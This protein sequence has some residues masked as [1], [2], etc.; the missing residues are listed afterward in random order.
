M[1]EFYAPL[2][3]PTHTGRGLS[4]FWGSLTAAPTCF[5]GPSLVG[6]ERRTGG[7]NATPC[8]AFGWTIRRC[9]SFRNPV[10][11]HSVHASLA[12]WI[13]RR[14]STP[15]RPGFES[16][17]GHGRER[18]QG[19]ATRHFRGSLSAALTPWQ[20]PASLRCSTRVE[21]LRVRR[22]GGRRRP[23]MV[24]AQW[25]LRASHLHGESTSG[26][27]FDSSQGRDGHARARLR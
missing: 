25:L 8:E 9:V 1:V 20:L 26:V 7:R 18:L 2:P 6:R 3:A 12:Q 10:A 22:Y 11:S 15:R 24:T 5:R 4:C 21:G 14:S 13:E 17:V 23:L 19:V 16:S 27:R